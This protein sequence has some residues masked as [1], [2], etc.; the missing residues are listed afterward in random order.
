M[1]LSGEAFRDFGSLWGHI[2]HTTNANL[3]H[4]ILGLGTY[5][6]PIDNISK[7]NCAMRHIVRKPCGLKAGRYAECMIEINDYLVGGVCSDLKKW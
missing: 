7:K 5:F 6:F 4:I 3:N 1:S 2:G